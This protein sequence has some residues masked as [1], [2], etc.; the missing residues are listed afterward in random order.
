MVDRLPPVSAQKGNVMATAEEIRDGLD[1]LITE[2]K[3][4]RALAHS[5]VVV[6]MEDSHDVFLIRLHLGQNRIS[7]AY[8]ATVKAKMIEFGWFQHED[9]GPLIFRHTVSRVHKYAG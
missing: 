7:A 9:D 3:S 4:F 5:R 8:V 2:A 1:F 6:E